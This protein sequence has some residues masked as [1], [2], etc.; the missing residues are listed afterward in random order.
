VA[1][2][3]RALTFEGAREYV[4]FTALWWWLKFG[5]LGLAAYI[6]WTATLIA[7]GLTVWRRHPDAIVRACGLGAGLGIVG[8]AIAEL[9]G[10][11]AGAD[12]RSA[13]VIG[14]LA[15]LLEAARRD[16]L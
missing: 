10:T 7:T 8:L 9:T 5:I 16:A 15:G 14:A 6:A 12:P 3:P 11:F 4:H 1:G 2:G 13:I